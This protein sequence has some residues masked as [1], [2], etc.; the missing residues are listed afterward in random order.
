MVPSGAGLFGNKKGSPLV[1]IGDPETEI[2]FVSSLCGD[3]T[4]FAVAAGDVAVWVC[5]S[6]TFSYCDLYDDTRSEDLLLL[7]V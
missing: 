4:G 1:S 7:M 5:F 3:K 6:M 2:L